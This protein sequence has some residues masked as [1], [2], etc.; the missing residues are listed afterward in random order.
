L[1]QKRE[2]ERESCRSEFREST[3]KVIAR[4]ELDCAKKN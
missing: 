2:R 3:V 4:K 1:S